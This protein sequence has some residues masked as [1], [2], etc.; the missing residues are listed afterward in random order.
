MRQRAR[1]SSSVSSPQAFK[2]SG[3]NS[4]YLAGY[5]ASRYSWWRLS[6]PRLIG[7]LL[8]LLVFIRAAHFWT[9]VHPGLEIEDDVRELMSTHKE[10][11]SLLLQD[12]DPGYH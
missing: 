12:A 4:H 11:A 5:L 2:A 1:A 8:A 9:V 3:T 10:L 6:R 7:Y